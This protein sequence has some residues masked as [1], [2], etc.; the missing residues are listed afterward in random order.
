MKSLTD[1]ME[2]EMEI[3]KVRLLSLI[4]F[5]QQSAR[6]RSKP[7]ASIESY[8]IFSLLEHDKTRAHYSVT[9]RGISGKKVA[10]ELANRPG[11]P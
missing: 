4:E 7:A 2:S 11:A 8:G 1:D 6:L 3:E 10:N 9:S 5:S